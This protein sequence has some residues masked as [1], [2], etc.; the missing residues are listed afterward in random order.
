MLNF[1]KKQTE[2]T[3]TR[4]IDIL[5][6]FYSEQLPRHM[7]RCLDLWM[8]KGP[9]NIHIVYSVCVCVCMCVCV[10]VCVCLCVCVCVCVHVYVHV[11]VIFIILT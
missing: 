11:C 8:V 7:F 5:M 3:C 9:V 10:C 4:I 2:L 1:H 6:T